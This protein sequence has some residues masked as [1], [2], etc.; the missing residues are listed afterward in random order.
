MAN[1]N[2]LGKTGES[3]A[4]GFLREK[5]YQI[6]FSNWRYAH[7]EIDIIATKGKKI[8]FIEVKTR[9]SAK[10]GYPE[11]SVNVKKFNYLKN[12]ADQYLHLNPGFQWIQF[13]IVSITLKKDGN[14]EYFFIEDIY[15]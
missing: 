2:E 11:E 10:F 9:S 13:D 15:L 14:P 7:Y 1:H 12:A 6:L 4:A 3:L 8:H 5:G